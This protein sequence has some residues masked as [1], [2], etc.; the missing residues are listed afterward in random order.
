MCTRCLRGKCIV[1]SYNNGLV[2]LFGTKKGYVQESFLGKRGAIVFGMLKGSSWGIPGAKLKGF[3]GVNISSS[4]S[5]LRCRWG[6]KTLTGRVDLFRN[7]A[8]LSLYNLHSKLLLIS[9]RSGAH[10]F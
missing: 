7:S 5:S 6:F 9:N 2:E 3:G 4:L 10:H 8:R 1:V